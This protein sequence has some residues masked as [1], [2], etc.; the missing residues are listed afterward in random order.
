MKGFG[1]LSPIYV[2]LLHFYLSRSRR[3]VAPGCSLIKTNIVTS[4]LPFSNPLFI[5]LFLSFHLFSLTGTAGALCPTS[6]SVPEKEALIA[7]GVVTQGKTF[8]SVS[9]TAAIWTTCLF[10]F[11][12]FAPFMNCFP[13]SLRFRLFFFNVTSVE[14]LAV[15][16]CRLW[17]TEA[18]TGGIW[19]VAQTGCHG[20]GGD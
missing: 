17:Y 2:W 12:I 19:L 9:E 18:A 7:V 5:Y 15:T 4:F 6:S 8:P 16:G 11:L 14:E 10:Y 1:G 3:P 13:G 20:E